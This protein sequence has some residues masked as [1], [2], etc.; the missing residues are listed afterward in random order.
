MDY[1]LLLLIRKMLIYFL[2]EMG[3]TVNNLTYST[4][5]GKMGNIEYLA[6][7]SKN[8]AIKKYNVDEIILESHK[9]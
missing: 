1:L 4:Q 5:Q 9:L 3:L 6:L 8:K 2:N 7:V